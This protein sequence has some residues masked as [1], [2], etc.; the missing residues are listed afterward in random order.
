M[1]TPEKYQ[2][3]KEISKG[4]IEKAV[5]LGIIFNDITE[6]EKISVTQK[7]IQDQ[8]DILIAQT[9]QREPRQEIDTDRAR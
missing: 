7:E 8:L 4:S 9:K 2:R 1:A 6:K 3:F 5:K